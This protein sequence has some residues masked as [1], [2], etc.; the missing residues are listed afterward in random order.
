MTVPTNVPANV[1]AN[2]PENVPENVMVLHDLGAPLGGAPWRAVAPSDWIVPD[3]PGHGTSRA[4]RTGHYDPMAPVAIARWLLPAGTNSTLIGVREQAHSALV[5]AAG[6]GCGRVV[7]VDGLGGPWFTPREQIDL[8]HASLR[9]I[10]DDRSATDPAPSS[11]LDP[12]ARYPYG[13]M[14]SRA[15]A[16][17]FWATIDQ[18]V[19]AIETPASVTPI[20]E[21]AERVAWFAGRS[22]LAVLESDEP[23]AIVAAVTRWRRDG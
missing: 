6:G 20:D 9:A 5:H 4:P 11:G 14:T 1:P 22:T 13:V 7:V 18:P 19:L 3:L 23:A 8:F 10:V 12:R 15:F 17:R 21:R 2:V 16:Q